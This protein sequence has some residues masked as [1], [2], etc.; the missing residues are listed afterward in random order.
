MCIVLYRQVCMS[1]LDTQPQLH[2]AEDRK[3]VYGII[4]CSM[5][6][7]H[8]TKTNYLLPRLDGTI[9][10]HLICPWRFITLY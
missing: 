8:L 7:D 10:K 9:L 1:F 3:E 6:S 4:G 2:R 5:Q